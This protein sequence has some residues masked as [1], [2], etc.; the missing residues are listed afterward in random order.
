M[1]LNSKYCDAFLAVAETQSFDAAA[2]VLNITA[3]AV[4]LR[5]Q[6]LE[7]SLGQVLIMRERPCKVTPAGQTLMEHL[8]QQRLREQ[9]L[10]QQLHGLG[11]EEFKVLHVATNADSLATWL[12]PTLSEILLQENI[13]LKL[14]VADQSQTHMLLE[15]GKVNACISSHAQAMKGCQAQRIGSMRYRMVATPVFIQRWFSQGIHRESLRKAPAII[16]NAQDQMHSHALLTHYGLSQH[17]YPF[18]YIPASTA[19]AE[20]VFAGLGYG[21]V[22]DFQIAHRIQQ[23]TLVE[24]LPACRT[25][26]DL[27][28]HHWKQQ[29]PVLKQ[30]TQVIL[31]QAE[32]HLNSPC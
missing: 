29:F 10:L 2:K 22:P 32:Q 1:A 6:S 5:M 9:Q 31:Q 18:H 19:F 30:L 16:Y 21:L 4:T 24:I 20:A 8:Q 26:I 7:K 25:D 23:N 17:S 27:Y 28:W 14:Q 3:S 12:L 15:T 13:S 11:T